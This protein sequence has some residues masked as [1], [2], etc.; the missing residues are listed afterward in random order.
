MRQHKYR[1]TSSIARHSHREHQ[2][3]N[4]TGK[5]SGQQVTQTALQGCDFTSCD[6]MSSIFYRCH[7]VKKY[8][9]S[10]K[11]PF[12]F[13]S[14]FSPRHAFTYLETSLTGKS[15]QKSYKTDSNH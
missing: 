4:A 5:I 13:Q 15:F 9:K 7:I 1:S 10:G 3:W 8:Y 14:F 12:H 6:F 11:I 2:N